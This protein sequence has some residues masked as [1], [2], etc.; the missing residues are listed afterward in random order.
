MVRPSN[1]PLTPTPRRR[2]REPVISPAL[3]RHR[4]TP[5]RTRVRHR[6]RHRRSLHTRV[7]LIP[8]RPSLIQ[9]LHPPTPPPF[10]RPTPR[11]LRRPL[12]IRTPIHTRAPTP[13]RAPRPTNPAPNPRQE[14]FFPFLPALPPLL[15]HPDLPP[16]RAPIVHLVRI[17]Q[18]PRRS[19]PAARPDFSFAVAVRPGEVEGV[20]VGG[21]DAEAEED[22]V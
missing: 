10:C 16:T 9:P 20:D 1:P 7:P 19:R 18:P 15:Q 3:P 4:P 12:P 17:H 5:S 14:P 11:P 13:T 21:E 6:R 2:H 22:A 8:S